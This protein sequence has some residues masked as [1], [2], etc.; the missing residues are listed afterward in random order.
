[1]EIFKRLSLDEHEQVVF[2]YD[3]ETGLKAIIALHSTVLGPALGGCRM[4]SYQTE[5]EA[6]IDV[7]RLSQGM[8]YK[9]SITGLNL[10]GGKSVIIGNPKI[11][12]NKN[13]L[14]KFGEFVDKLS[15][16]YIT[17]KDV[18]IDSKDLKIISTKTKYCLGIEGIEG[19]SGDPSPATAWGVYHGIKACANFVYGSPSL[20]G[21]KIAIQGLGAVAIS[22][23]KFLLNEG[24]QI[25]AT[26]IDESKVNFAI[27]E[28][29]IKTC[30]TEEILFQDVDIVSP[31]AM[32]AVLNEN[33]IPKLKCKIVAGA[34]N[35]QL[36]TTQSGE[37]LF[38]RG[39]V[40]APDYAINAGGLTNIYFE[41][42]RKYNQKEAYDF[43]AKIYNT[44][45]NILIRS[46]NENLPTNIVADKIAKERIENQKRILNGQN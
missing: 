13:L 46:K 43:I 37:M 40:Y 14:E 2:C 45:E 34:A 17:A 4:Y 18:G 3:K 7:L 33:T 27:K 25:I 8:T 44:I 16:N 11:Q 12:K 41:M 10:G 9:A 26:D 24:A 32:G 39:I 31:C 22:L 21:K 35:N 20:H 28:Y 6:L 36:A 15:G 29:G 23:I 19:S 42:N 5:E 30:A 38:N 1:M